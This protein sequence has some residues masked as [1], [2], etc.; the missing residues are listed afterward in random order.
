MQHSKTR[1]VLIHAPWDVLAKQAEHLRLK[2]PLRKND[3]ETDDKGCVDKILQSFETFKIEKEYSVNDPDY[4]TAL[5]SV[6]RA[7]QYVACIIIL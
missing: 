4:F 3:V 7:E 1:F 6:E 2:M 5:F